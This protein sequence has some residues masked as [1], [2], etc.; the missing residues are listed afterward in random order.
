MFRPERMTKTS[1]I[2]VK[3]DIEPT[4]QALSNFGEFHIEQVA[5]DITTVEY[6]ESIQKAEE[7]LVIVNELI[8][9]LSRE[10]QGYST[11][12]GTSSQ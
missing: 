12:L 4:L 2:C 9:E 7:S 5:E 1:I 6:V 3:Q 10:K 8:K 11:F